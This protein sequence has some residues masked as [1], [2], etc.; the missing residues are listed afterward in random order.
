MINHLVLA[1]L[2]VLH[3]GVRATQ[4]GVARAWPPRAAAR[5]RDRKL[6]NFSSNTAYFFQNT[7]LVILVHAYQVGWT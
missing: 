6:G 1:I 7:W 5:V 3:D 4:L 2:S